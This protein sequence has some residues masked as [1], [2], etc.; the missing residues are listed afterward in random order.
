MSKIWFVLPAYNEEKSIQP[1]FDSIVTTMTV[2]NKEYGILVVNDGSTDGTER[3]LRGYEKTLPL[4]IVNNDGNKGLA[5]TIRRGLFEVSQIADPNDM[6]CTMDADNTHPV[7]LVPR[8]ERLIEEGNDIVIASRYREGSH[9]RGLTM[10]RRFLSFV[11]SCLFRVV[12]PTPGVRDY[13]CGFRVAR[14]SAYKTL[15]TK[16][17]E[18]FVTERGFSCMVE[19][20]LKFRACDQF[21]FTEVPMVLRYDQKVGQ[22]KMRVFRTIFD[23][24][25]L[26]IRRRLFGNAA[27]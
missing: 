24:L 18:G 13:T 21:V 17:G 26:L 22:S 11:A 19:I 27:V 6:V 8:M 16:Y 9:I 15:I 12:F 4:V 25:K 23:T 14:V 2:E 7:G 3:V 10:F 5:E 1:L 20:L